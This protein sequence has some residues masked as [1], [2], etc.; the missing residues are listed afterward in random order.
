MSVTFK[1]DRASE[2]LMRSGEKMSARGLQVTKDSWIRLDHPLKLDEDYISGNSYKFE[3]LYDDQIIAV[4]I[5][6]NLRKCLYVLDSFDTIRGREYVIHP[7]HNLAEMINIEFY[8]DSRF[9]TTISAGRSVD[10]SDLEM[11]MV[12]DEFLLDNL[13]LSERLVSSNI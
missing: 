6:G 9:D 3:D 5:E 7:S 8:G 11:F 12:S 1:E 10:P 13:G 2:I 4:S